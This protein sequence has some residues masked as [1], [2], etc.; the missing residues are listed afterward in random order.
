M[1]VHRQQLSF[2][3]G[4]P[5]VSDRHPHLQE[6]IRNTIPYQIHQHQQSALRSPQQALIHQTRT[7]LSSS[8][9]HRSEAATPSPRL[10]T[11]DKRP[12]ASGLRDRF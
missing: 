1:A 3:V 7:I 4:T 2:R 8:R 5:S 6:V 12:A 11:S 10:P 9:N